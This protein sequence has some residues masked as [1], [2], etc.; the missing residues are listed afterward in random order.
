MANTT[1]TNGTASAVITSKINSDATIPLRVPSALKDS[2][3][4]LAARDDRSLSSYI[5]RLLEAHAAAALAPA[6]PAETTFTMKAKAKA[7]AKAR[8][9]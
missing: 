2:L 1:N 8:K 7:K 4:I 3:L 6:A 5:K 9:K